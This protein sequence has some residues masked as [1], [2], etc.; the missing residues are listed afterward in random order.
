MARFPHL[1]ND[2]IV[3][4][5]NGF[6]SI[7][8][9]DVP[10]IMLTG[11]EEFTFFGFFDPSFKDC[12]DKKNSERFISYYG[13]EFYRNFNTQHSAYKM[14]DHYKS[15]IYLC[16]INY[17]D[18]NSKTS[19]PMFKSFH[20]IFVPMLTPN[21]HGY[22]FY[23]FKESGYLEMTDRYHE[24][25]SS[26]VRTGIPSGCIEW[27]NWTV[28]NRDTLILDAI[29]GKAEIYLDNVYKSN[30]EIIDEMGK[31]S[32]NEVDRMNLIR[33]VLNGRWFS[34][35]LDEYYNNEN[36]WDV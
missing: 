13:G 18:S 3:I 17:G 31:D 21:E 25:I 16:Q 2:G 32:L 26:F 34:S 12:M 30:H 28:E 5:S 36:R 6:D 33:N 20:G 9:N 24:Y 7:Y 29:D 23:D 1:Y 22:R 8:I 27:K 35:D 14:I 11:S 4:P 10:I 15:N 19:I